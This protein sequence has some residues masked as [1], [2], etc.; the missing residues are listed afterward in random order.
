[1]LKKYNAKTMWSDLHSEQYITGVEF[2]QI[3]F[4]NKTTKFIF[5]LNKNRATKALANL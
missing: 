1:M 2:L 4:Q 5:D 3:L